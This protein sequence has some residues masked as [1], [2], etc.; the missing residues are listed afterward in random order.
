MCT[1]VGVDTQPLTPEH[2][3]QYHEPM[4]ILPTLSPDWRA[5]AAELVQYVG[6]L[7]LPDLHKKKRLSM[8]P[9]YSANRVVGDWAEAMILRS[10]YAAGLAAISCGMSEAGPITPEHRAAV[11][12]EWENLGKRPDVLLGAAG[13]SLSPFP[14]GADLAI[15]SRSSFKLD[16]A[17]YRAEKGKELSLTL[18]VEDIM[19]QSRWTIT[20]GIPLIIGQ[21]LMSPEI[22]AISWIDALGYALSHA[23]TADRTSGKNTFFIPFDAPGVVRLGAAWVPEEWESQILRQPDGSMKPVFKARGCGLVQLEQGALN[24]LATRF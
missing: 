21:V 15:E 5:R 22:W 18:K 19:P 17:T 12:A 3:P 4:L 8:N 2:G 23:P 11:V 9:A 6:A 24:A 20:T 7:P 10:A 16:A 1:T 14:G 13:R